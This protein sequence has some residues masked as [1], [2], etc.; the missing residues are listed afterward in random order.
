MA[1]HPSKQPTERELK[2]LKVL[3]GLG[4]ARLSEVAAKI[5]ESETIALTT[6]A[7]MLKLMEGKRLVKRTHKKGQTLWV[8]TATAQA[9]R[10]GFLKSVAETLFDGSSKWLVSHLL[11]QGTLSKEEEAEIV[12]LL[13]ERNHE[14]NE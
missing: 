11:E 10:N 4:P 2:I 8:A 9:T 5:R 1:R 7:T 6:V 14:E 3:W 13:K 12:A